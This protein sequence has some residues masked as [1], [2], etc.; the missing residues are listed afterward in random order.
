[1]LDVG[2]L[3]AR[4]AALSDGAFASAPS[5]K[6]QLMQHGDA[7]GLTLVASENGRGFLRGAHS[8]QWLMGFDWTA[9]QALW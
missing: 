5:T 7:F 9:A 6:F 8:R 1:M 3:R 4:Y 2:R